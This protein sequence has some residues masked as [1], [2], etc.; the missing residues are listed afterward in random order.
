MNHLADRWAMTRLPA[1]IRKDCQRMHELW[2]KSLMT[3]N[4]VT[5]YKND[6]TQE[7]NHN[8]YC[9]WARNSNIH[10]YKSIKST[11]KYQPFE[12]VQKRF[13]SISLC[14]GFES[15]DFPKEKNHLSVCVAM[16]VYNHLLAPTKIWENINTQNATCTGHVYIKIF[17][18]WVNL[19]MFVSN[20]TRLWFL[21]LIR[22]PRI[23]LVHWNLRCDTTIHLYKEISPFTL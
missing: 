10:L 7:R 23:S 12:N 1:W 3:R 16:V 22:G 19:S 8:I 9:G 2:L 11:K 15:W 4:L 14:C 5:L 17:S 6:G 18:P 13:Y 21:H 20:Y